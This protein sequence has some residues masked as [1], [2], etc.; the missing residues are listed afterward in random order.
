MAEIHVTR[1][2]LRAVAK[3]DLPPRVLVESGLEHLLSLCPYCREEYLAWRTE[4]GAQDY[5][6]AFKVLPALLARHSGELG[7]KHE[8]AHRDLRFLLGLP[9][10]E[11]LL[12]ITRAVTR[13]RGA[14]LAG[15]ILD[16]SKKRMASNPRE[17]Y[18]L[19]EAADAVLLRSH[20]SPGVADGFARASAYMAN[21]LRAQ[22]NLRG[23]RERFK[24][25]RS[26]IQSQGVTNPLIYAEVDS[27]EAVL[28]MDQRRFGEALA[29]IHRSVALYALA[30]AKEEAAHPLTTLGL[31]YYHQGDLEQAI[32]ATRSATALIQPEQNLR[33]YLGVRHNLTLFLSEA[34]YYEVASEAL[35]RD[36]P[37]Y[38]EF[39]DLYTKLRFTW[40]EG[41]I[42]LGLGREAAAESAFL[43]TREG[44]VSQGI[45]YDVAMVSLDLAL[46]YT[47]QG[48]VEE[49]L[50]LSEEMHKI[51]AA[52]DIH[53][54]AVAALLIFEEAA[55]NQEVTV[56]LVERLARYLKR[57]RNNPELRFRSS[58]Q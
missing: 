17:A 49:L 5:D 8:K 30:G 32:E 54:E 56:D 48:R 15:M 36:R 22:G 24:Y 42:A 14:L 39:S 20:R 21:A 58:P 26:L 12:K 35:L 18:E 51:F 2:L 23:A 27:A 38:E 47:K 46:L 55:R 9:H 44:F 1:E 28:E 13:F 40:L 29:L 57:A 41:R 31:I 11:R 53:R 50:S 4:G 16:E 3:G 52:K 37:L 45:G 10:Q 33:L 34:G 7:E 6:A 25:T 19:A 43:A